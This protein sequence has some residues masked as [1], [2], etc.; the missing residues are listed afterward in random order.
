MAEKAN[1]GPSTIYTWRSE[2]DFALR[3]NAAQHNEDLLFPGSN[4]TRKHDHSELLDEE[5]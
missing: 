4:G 1:G 2:G 5:L 3:L